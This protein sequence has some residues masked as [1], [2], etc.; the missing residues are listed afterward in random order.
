[1]ELIIS[2]VFFVLCFILGTRIVFRRGRKHGEDALHIVDEQVERSFGR[3]SVDPVD[4]PPPA[5]PE[6]ME[7]PTDMLDGTSM[8]VEAGKLSLVIERARVEVRHD[9]A[10]ES[11]TWSTNYHD[12]FTAEDG[13]IEQSGY[14]EFGWSRQP[15]DKLVV[16]VPANFRGDLSITESRGS[17]ISVDHW[18][19]G[20]VTVETNGG[21]TLTIGRIDDG[22]AV[23]I[24]SRSGMGM[25]LGAWNAQSANLSLEDAGSITVGDVSVE[26]TFTAALSGNGN[27]KCGAINAHTFSTTQSSDG[28]F[29]SGDIT[30]VE[31]MTLHVND[32]GGASVGNVHGGSVEI[33]STDDAPVKAGH[34]T[35]GTTVLLELGDGYHNSLYASG[36]FE[37][38]SG[39]T[40]VNILAGSDRALNIPGGITVNEGGNFYFRST[41]NGTTKVGDLTAN[42]VSTKVT[43]DGSVTFGNVTASGNFTSEQTDDGHLTLGN[44]T[45]AGS[46]IS[47]QSDDGNFTCGDITAKS[48]GLKSSDDGNITARAVQSDSSVEIESGDGYHESMYATVKLDS[49]EAG[50]K[51]DIT[52]GADHPLTIAERILVKDGGSFTLTSKMGGATS[53]G[54]IYAGDVTIAV[55]GDGH[56]K[57]GNIKAT[58]SFTSQQS[59]DGNLTCGNIEAAGHLTSQQSDNGNFS[60]GDINAFAVKMT[61]SDDGTIT[62]REMVASGSVRLETGDGYHDNMYALFTLAS[63]KAGKNVDIVIGTDRACKI[64]GDVIIDEGGNF[65]LKSTMDGNFD[66]GA[67]VANDIQIELQSNGNATLRNVTGSGRFTSK[68]TDDGNLTL[69]NISIRGALDVGLSDDGRFKCGDIEAQAVKIV[70]SDDG[71]VNTGKIESD[72]AVVLV[73]G[74]S[75]N[76]NATTQFTIASVDAG[77]LADITVGSDYPLIISGGVN[78]KDGGDFK[79]KSTMN[80]STTIGGVT[81]GNVRAE[82]T[83][84]GSINLG[85]VNAERGSV[86]TR[87]TDDGNITIGGLTCQRFDGELTD[88]GAL[89]IGETHAEQK[90]YAITKGRGNIRVRGCWTRDLQVESTD[91]GNVNVDAGTAERVFSNADGSGRVT[92]AQSLRPRRD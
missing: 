41:L 21:G 82:S 24:I 48:V 67:L 45:V 38:I 62:A 50:T 76:S 79:L 46:F 80:G 15:A 25:S 12:H 66:A 87:Q 58:G 88:Y 30:V 13:V 59:D 32:D 2:I 68:Q 55:T 44:V 42:N 52:N 29:E 19:G 70:S 16:V 49:I 89:T 33:K 53:A 81:A 22:K 64:A 57:L 63:M 28:K 69:G 71:N 26:G 74:D 6:L 61:S 51:V 72:S 23:R 20:N 34:V 9:E 47:V 4:P 91:D 37:S 65:T 43:G 56:V 11:I 36:T 75:Y 85:N 31:G 92:L 14:K 90:F 18:A 73:S 84:D 3:S 7:A 10:A 8:S 35:S 1:M 40:S 86:V 5:E 54:D 83:G 78:V 60:C 17:S 77:T 27:L 39:G